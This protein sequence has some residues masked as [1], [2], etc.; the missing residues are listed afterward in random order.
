MML[1]YSLT[2]NRHTKFLFFSNLL[3]VECFSSSIKK[4]NQRIIRIFE[5]REISLVCWKWDCSIAVQMASEPPYLG[6]IKLQCCWLILTPD[7]P[8]GQVFKLRNTVKTFQCHSNHWPQ[9]FDLK[10]QRIIADVSKELPHR[11]APNSIIK[12]CLLV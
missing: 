6:Y 2:L 3:F 9:L 10:K 4:K 11:F 8:V 7:I 12:T 1:C 5:K